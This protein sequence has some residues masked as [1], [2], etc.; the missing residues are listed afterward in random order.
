[1]RR[2]GFNQEQQTVSAVYPSVFDLN[3]KFLG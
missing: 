2:N 1:M 3:A